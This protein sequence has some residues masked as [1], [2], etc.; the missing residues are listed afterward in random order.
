MGKVRVAFYLSL[1]GYGAGPDQSLEDPLGRGGRQLHDW[2][3][4]TRFFKTMLGQEGGSEGI[5]NDIMASSFDNLGAWV[6]GRNMFGPVRGDWGDN[7]WKGWWDDNPPFHL[8]VFVLTNHERKAV[9][10]EGGTTFHFVT[11][12]AAPAL[13]R[14]QEAAG[15]RDVRIGGGVVTVHQFLQARAVDEMHLA[16][17]PILLGGGEA[18]WDGLDLPALGYRLADNVDGERATHFFIERA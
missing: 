9:E 18:F 6:I 14:A 10:M 11:D 13:E 12:G 8:P 3:F 2:M 16:I 15:N 1:D 7:S 4:A 17:S 5:D